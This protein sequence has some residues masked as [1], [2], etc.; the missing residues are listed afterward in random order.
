MAAIH[1]SVPGAVNDAGIP[2][3]GVLP[4][5]GRARVLGLRRLQIAGQ[6]QWP[7]GSAGGPPEPRASRVVVDTP[8]DASHHPGMRSRL[9]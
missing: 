8:K 3:L 4:A 7:T 5:P 1:S 2:A 9:A 6:R